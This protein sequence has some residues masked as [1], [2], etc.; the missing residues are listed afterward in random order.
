MRS[1]GARLSAKFGVDIAPSIDDADD[2]DVSAFDDVENH[3]VARDQASDISTKFRPHATD[4]WKI[5]KV[6]QPPIDSLENPICGSWTAFCKV[7]MNSDQIFVG[8][9]RNDDP[10]HEFG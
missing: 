2:G 1:A 9:V 4:K 10:H 6:G 8:L 5:G 7:R 3:P